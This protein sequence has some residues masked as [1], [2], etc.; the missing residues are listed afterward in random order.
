MSEEM[1]SLPKN[2]C[3][4]G[5]DPKTLSAK[6]NLLEFARGPCTPAILVPGIFASRLMIEIDCDS[7]R[8]NQPDVFSVCGWNSCEKNWWE[9]WLSQPAPEYQIWITDVMSPFSI[10]RISL[11]S[12]VCLTALLA[13]SFDFSRPI[14]D[15]ILPSPGITIRP[16]G[17]T[18]G[19]KSSSGCGRSALQDLLPLPVQ[20]A[21][22]VN[23]GVINTELERLGFVPGLTYQSLPY[24]FLV[25]MR[26]NE[27]SENFA[28]V[29]KR[30][31][32]TTGKKVSLAAHSLGNVN[33]L[34]Q[35]EFFSAEE[36]D[37]LFSNWVAIGAPFLG[38]HKAYKSI[39]SGIRDFA[40]LHEY[41]GIKFLA[42]AI[43]ASSHVSSYELGFVDPFKAF[44]G[45]P[46][47]AKIRKRIHYET[48][49]PNVPFE[50]S[51]IPFWP[52][53]EEKCHEEQIVGVSPQ[54]F[55]GAFDSSSLPI[56]TLE[57]ENYLLRDLPRV[58]TTFNIT[59]NV[60][61]LFEKTRNLDLY[62]KNPSIPLINI[63][64]SSIPSPV[65][66]H[67]K[68]GF[69]DYVKNLRFP[70][71][72]E[73]GL[74]PGDETVPSIST[75]GMPLKWALEFEADPKSSKPVKF[76]ELC[77]TAYQD[78]QIFDEK[79]PE[80]EF[81]I[82][83]NEYLG[84]RCKCSDQKLKSFEPC[85]HPSM[86]SDPAIVNLVA[87]VLSANQKASE[88]DIK[89]IEELDEAKLNEEL[90]TCSYLKI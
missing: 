35:L 7:L 41:L 32:R 61:H 34:K 1:A 21:D 18:P 78:R 69:K 74:V 44:E 54:C 77:S 17:F 73:E 75:L 60:S 14:E 23:F 55:L 50:E 85:H 26:K 57:E 59:E 79:D 4:N 45:Q 11:R 30:L 15:M 28:A 31:R 64:S 71:I 89:V 12:N 9:A 27:F 58:Y 48:N 39:L 2:H 53:I 8:Q 90:K 86:L 40:M 25:T 5:K 76:V 6:Q 20:V 67:Y 83:K 72:E 82:T 24:N 33:I 3:L 22:T 10:F 56:F 37:R 19:S 88:E 87:E 13:S 63:F 38:A 29:A 36:K 46:W 52:P 66:W 43:L 42:A 70:E 49:H 51:G 65:Y 62:Q 84:L 80:K 81:R 47:L 16:H 68:K